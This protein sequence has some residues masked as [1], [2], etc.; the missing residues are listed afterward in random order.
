MSRISSLGEPGIAALSE[1]VLHQP[2]DKEKRLKA[3][4][5]KRIANQP[6][7]DIQNLSYEQV[8]SIIG[9]DALKASWSQPGFKAWFCNREEYR[10]RLEYLFELAMDAAEDILKNVDPKAQSARVNMVKTIS[11]LAGKLQKGN[12]TQN[13]TALINGTIGQMDKAQLELYLQKNGVNLHLS[14]QKNEGPETAEVLD[15]S[16]LTVKKIDN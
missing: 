8:R 4:F 1:E 14:A 10:E 9:T 13:A 11:E 6:L 5:W 3:S 15:V 16:E 2:T 7:F 12:A